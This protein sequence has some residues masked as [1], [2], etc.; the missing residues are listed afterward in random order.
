[1]KELTIFTRIRNDF[2]K[3][4]DLMTEANEDFV[5]EKVINN[6]VAEAPP[7]S[8]IVLYVDDLD[9]CPPRRVVEVLQ[10]IHLLLAFP[11]FVVVV[12]VDARWVRRSLLDRFALMLSRQTATTN[13]APRKGPETRTPVPAL[14]GEGATPDDYLEKIFQIAFW[15]RPLSEA[16]SKTL[17]Q[18]LTKSDGPVVSS[19]PQAAESAKPAEGEQQKTAGSPPAL[20]GQAAPSGAPSGAGVSSAAPV[21]GQR[22]E[23]TPVTAQPRTLHISDSEREYMEKLALLIGRS[24][25][26]V[27]RFLN[28]YRLIKAMLQPWELTS[29]VGS[30]QLGATDGLYHPTMLLLATVTGAPELGQ[31]ICSSLRQRTGDDFEAWLTSVAPHGRLDGYREWS[32]ISAELRTIHRRYSAST[33]HTLRLAAERVDRFAFTPSR[34]PEREESSAPAGRKKSRTPSTPRPQ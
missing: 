4:S 28:S 17:V 33:L 9:R 19:P 3:L 22:F 14:P 16:T 27:K 13:G 1:L 18:N 2:Q 5:A 31:M 23:W 21:T 34:L 15:L 32:T 10:A 26:A 30:G 7:V 11:L 29:F 24:P 12:A 25:R 20:G 8:R 6:V